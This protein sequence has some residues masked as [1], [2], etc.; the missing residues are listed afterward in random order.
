MLQRHDGPLR[1]VWQPESGNPDNRAE[2]IPQS[3]YRQNSRSSSSRVLMA[4][5]L[6]ADNAHNAP[7]FS[8]LTSFSAFAGRA[9]LQTQVRLA[10]RGDN[11][12][13]TDCEYCSGQRSIIDTT[14]RGA[15]RISG[16]QFDRF[17]TLFADAVVVFIF[18]RTGA[19]EFVLVG[20]ERIVR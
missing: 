2:S 4:P 6:N 11:R 19:F 5:V 1:R 3:A 7:P 13:G 14:G 18:S 15:F 9:N 12:I 10:Y 17:H 20:E 8:S 16:K